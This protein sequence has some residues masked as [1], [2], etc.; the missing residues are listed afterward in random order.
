[1]LS[2]ISR[3][4]SEAVKWQFTLTILRLSLPSLKSASVVL[5]RGDTKVQSGWAEPSKGF[6]TFSEPLVI[7]CTLYKKRDKSGHSVY[8]SKEGELRVME[9]GKPKEAG[10]VSLDFS[11]YVDEEER[12]VEGVVEEWRIEKSV[13]K[14]SNYINVKL[15]AKRIGGGA[16]GAPGGAPIPI[17]AAAGRKEEVKELPENDE[18][19]DEEEREWKKRNAKPPAAK[20]GS[21]AASKGR[22]RGRDE[23]EEEEQEEE[24]EEQPAEEEEEDV[25]DEDDEDDSPK[26]PPTAA[27]RQ[28]KQREEEEEAEFA[29]R[30][31]VGKGGG[32][33]GPRSPAAKTDSKANVKGGKPNG[34]LGEEKAGKAQPAAK[35]KKDKSKMTAK[36][37][38]FADSSDEEEEKE[39]QQDDDEQ[40]DEEQD[41]R[42]KGKA[43]A[44]KGSKAVVGKQQ[45]P[46]PQPPQSARAKE[47]EQKEQK[48]REK[49]KDVKP[50]KAGGKGLNW[51]VFIP[52]I[53]SASSSPRAATAASAASSSSSSAAAK[54]ITAKQLFTCTLAE[55]ATVYPSSVKEPPA[56]P[57]VL[58][59]LL[60]AL[61]KRNAALTPS[62]FKQ[63]VE[64]AAVAALRSQLESG[65]FRLK[66]PH[67]DDP[68]ALGG[69]LKAWVGSLQDGLLVEPLIPDAL[70]IGQMEDAGAGDKYADADDDTDVKGALLRFIPRLSA[71]HRASL[72]A[73]VSFLHGFTLPLN[74]R[75]NGLTSAAL[76]S[77]WGSS[78][79]K[80]KPD[81]SKSSYDQFMD[82]S[83]ANRF[84]EFLIR[85][86]DAFREAKP[87][88]SAQSSAAPAG[89]GLKKEEP[90]EQE[91][92][93][94]EE[95]GVEAAEAAEESGDESAALKFHDDRD[96]EDE[97]E[98]RKGAKS[99]SVRPL[100]AKEKDRVEKERQ[101][102][103]EREKKEK[104]ERERKERADREKAE[105]EKSERERKER[106]E[107]ERKEKERKEKEDKERKEKE[108]KEK[109][110]LERE[111]KERKDKAAA[112]TAAASL[113]RKPPPAP[114]KPANVFGDS[115]LEDEEE[116]DDN[117][118]QDD[119]AAAETAGEPEQDDDYSALPVK[120]EKAKVE[121]ETAKRAA[122]PVRAEAG[123]SS[124]VK[125]RE[126]I[127]RLQ[128]EVET[129]RKQQSEGGGAGKA[130]SA[131]GDL[132][133][134]KKQLLAA[135]KE[136]DVALR[137]QRESEKRLVGLESERD[138]QQAMVSKLQKLLV[139]KG[140]VDASQLAELG[141]QHDGGSSGSREREK[142]TAGGKSG[143]GDKKLVESLSVLQL[144]YDSAVEEFSAKLEAERSI[145]KQ[146]KQQLEQL[147]EENA[148]LRQ[149]SLHF[150]QLC[151]E[152]P[153]AMSPSGSKKAGKDGLLHVIDAQYRR[154]ALL[155]RSMKENEEMTRQAKQAWNQ[156]ARIMEQEMQQRDDELQRLRGGY[157]QAVG[158]KGV[159]FMEA[160]ELRK[161]V[162]RLKREKE[163]A[164]KAKA[165]MEDE[166][167][168]ARQLQQEAQRKAEQLEEDV[169]AVKEELT[170][171]GLALKTIAEDNFELKEW[172]RLNTKG[173]KSSS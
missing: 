72:A 144:R 95:D 70:R 130:A 169:K 48:E 100:S 40:D 22:Q 99:G 151:T 81:S 149:R 9:K 133:D 75:K 103:A 168:G 19:E 96:E 154:I 167:A 86:H 67:G 98:H 157:E 85:Y 113:G 101:E 115:D 62:L 33:A 55:A 140:K 137:A 12:D 74:A 123:S 49:E 18:D 172:M 94:E 128:A 146:L 11:R 30:L 82:K 50:A 139:Q 143:E 155:E 136:K 10:V 104:E 59:F 153:P 162:D 69:V 119:D 87:P 26:K 79:V 158:G 166:L 170:R 150:D 44:A 77:A 131:G 41:V 37:L 31:T 114:L 93:E 45:Q 138:S 121:K 116:D 53:S 159:D 83:F 124:S 23:D 109:E 97:A 64:P 163:A 135:L 65:S 46:Q 76:A 171:S 107:K 7:V 122:S 90:E 126:Q 141:A 47:K 24:P 6:F 2:K 112:A 5:S 118:V 8:L 148:T 117:E 58:T 57:Y 88:G 110:R 127:A 66:S 36:E 38:L 71:L 161:R 1:M 89:A 17:A 108:R 165:D 160:E 51:E 56:V 106:E 34:R 73:L 164:E 35:V 152:A 16:A 78:I 21:A 156:T 145:R 80:A 20:S 60:S 54:S 29:R 63:Y 15:S 68:H 92:G 61:E 120:G 111:E 129:L 105:K 147:T 42:G 39:E 173:K 4:G 132:S 43:A 125:D 102:K 27:A 3:I 52:S 134:L 84:V 32:G 28:R 142:V 25:L 91:E 13:D 14:Y